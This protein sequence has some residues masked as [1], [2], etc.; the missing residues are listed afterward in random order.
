ME[1]R[2]L[3]FIICFSAT[4]SLWAQ[5]DLLKELDQSLPQEV[6]YASQ[7]FK[8]TRIINGQSIESKPEGTL[9][10]IF[11]HRFGSINGGSYELY[12]LDQA[13]VRLGLEYGIKD[14][15]GIGVGRNSQDKTIDGFIRY[16]LIRQSKGAKV[17]PFT[18]SAFGSTA[19]RT[20]P[21]TGV[22]DIDRLA[23]IGQLLIA[24]KFS[25]KLSLQLM[26][27]FVH[28]NAV[29]QRYENNDQFALGVGGRLKVTKSVAL[30]SEY[31]YRVNPHED[32][33]NY[34]SLGFGIDIETG[35]HV[36]Q[37]MLT[38]SQ[39]LTERA[40]ITET[41]EDFFDGGIHLGFNVTRTFQ[42]KRKKQ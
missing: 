31:Y 18:I 21:E 12:G 26:P 36:F 27:T 25:S 14:Y 23:Y 38:N 22:K 1:I 20:S 39:G 3:T 7:T 15:L 11:S 42:L 19:Y 8:G 24:R 10:F 29:D 6:E 35:G 40:F 13:F 9:E 17:F 33:P 32:N 5:D 2:L 34:N 4:T 30:T 28:K 41:D 37:L 16:R